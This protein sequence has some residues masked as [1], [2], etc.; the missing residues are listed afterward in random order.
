MYLKEE[1]KK[2]IFNY[3]KIILVTSRIEAKKKTIDHFGIF[4]LFFR[5]RM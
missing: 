3:R 4:F 2:K 1:E 5:K